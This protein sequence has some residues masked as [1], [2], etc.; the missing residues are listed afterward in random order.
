MKYILSTLFAIFLS[1]S[2][3]AL[4]SNFEIVAI[5]N[6]TAISTIDLN[7]RLEL[8]ISSSGLPDSPQTRQKL[9]PQILRT[10]IDEALYLQEAKEM[11]IDASPMELKQAIVKLEKQ[12]NLKQGTFEEFL[13]ENN[14]PISAMKKQIESQVIWGKILNKRVRSRIIITDREIEE[15]LEHISNVSGISELDISEIVLHVDS[16]EDAERIR[17]LAEKLLEEIKNGASFES[18][19]KEFSQSSTAS[20]GG[21]LGWVREEHALKAII[22]KVRNLQVGGVSSPFYENGNYYI[23]KLNDRRALINDPTTVKSVK[24]KH[25]FVEIK[26]NLPKSKILEIQDNIKSNVQNYKSCSDFAKF[27]K[28]I[29]SS[30]P[31]ETIAIEVSE[32][33]PEVKPAVIQTPVNS[34]TPPIPAPGGIHIFGVCDKTEPEKSIVLKERIEGMI[35]RRKMDL[36]AQRYLQDLRDKAFIEIRI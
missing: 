20:N 36:Q 27:A 29:N 3:N 19:A 15:K 5:V 25:A 13:K 8:S 10:L 22:S 2:S 4:A 1:F 16:P 30:L 24:M 6:D 35:L 9:K 12:N 31:T 11:R 23:I 7:E 21:S 26:N 18:I 28:N 14:I 34:L 32:L 17:L 33:N